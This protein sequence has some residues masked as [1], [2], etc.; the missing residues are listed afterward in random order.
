MTDETNSGAALDKLLSAIDGMTQRLDAL[1]K[2]QV[3]ADKQRRADARK[4]K[5]SAAEVSGV[6]PKSAGDP[7]DPDRKID[8]PRRL[9]ADNGDENVNLPEEIRRAK[10]L[11]EELYQ[12]ER[13]I[14]GAMREQGPLCEAEEG[15]MADAQARADSAYAALGKRAPAPLPG[16]RLSAYRVRL[17]RP[18]QRHSE[19]SSI[20]L[21]AQPAKNLDILE[22]KIFADAMSA[23][24]AGSHLPDG[25]L[26][27]ISKVDESGRRT[28][29]FRGRG[30]FV[31]NFKHPARVVSR[32][33]DPREARLR[34]LLQRGEI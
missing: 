20:D 27:P 4:R 17:L 32:I 15:L 24:D 5:D 34:E 23:A 3:A 14:S 16:E 22:P 10:A 18:L 26:L 8:E 6:V 9:A 12:M 28:T 30:S 2:R 1:E 25:E 7:D 11:R 29:E 31:R 21:A 33:L 19:F 13:R